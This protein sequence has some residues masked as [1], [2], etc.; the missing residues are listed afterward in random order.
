MS[1]ATTTEPAMNAAEILTKSPT[2]RAAA[3]ETIEFCAENGVTDPAA[4]ME[5]MDATV[6][7]VHAELERFVELALSDSDDGRTIRR[8]I[9]REVWTSIRLDAGLPVSE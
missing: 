1:N 7:R 5:I 3:A 9:M 4:I 8:A 2:L 6:R